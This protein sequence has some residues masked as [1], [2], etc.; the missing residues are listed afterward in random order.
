[1]DT[2][3]IST[4]YRI[5]APAMSIS[6]GTFK[7]ANQ[8]YTGSEILITDMSQFTGTNDFR[9]AYVTVNRQKVYLTLG[10]DF[11]VIPGSYLKNISQG[12]A[13]VMIRGINDYGGTKTVKFKIVKKSVVTNW[14]GIIESVMNSLF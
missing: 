1:M 7:I 4:E 12:T 8:E 9:N 6:K 2:G 5:I 14:G 13:S 3:K 10:E 11:E